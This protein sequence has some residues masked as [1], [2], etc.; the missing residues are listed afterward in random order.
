MSPV[1]QAFLFGLVSAC[2]LPLGALTAIFWQPSS[3]LVAVLMAFGGGALLAAL[4]IDLV[5]A[6]LSRGHFYPLAGGCIVGGLLFMALNQVVNNYG[7]FL[8]KS[9]TTVWYF[10]RQAGSTHPGRPD[11]GAGG[12]RSPRRPV[13]ARHECARGKL[14]EGPIRQCVPPS[15]QPRSANNSLSG[16]ALISMPTMASPRPRETPTMMSGSL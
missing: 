14:P 13:A 7:G 1:T 2:S 8:R 11:V 15:H 9:S 10:R 16:M 4:T 5:G 12:L 6:A 3:R